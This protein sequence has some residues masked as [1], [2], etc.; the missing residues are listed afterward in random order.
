MRYQLSQTDIVIR[1]ND[2]GTITFI[3]NDVR[4]HDRAIYEAWLGDQHTPDAA[5]P[6]AE[7][8]PTPAERQAVALA[9]AR[10]TIEASQTLPAEVKS[11][12]ADALD[13]IIGGLGV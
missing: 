1:H 13:T 7:P 11:V 3:P 9:D 10:A 6:L 8:E 12:L 2:D 4:N 5:D